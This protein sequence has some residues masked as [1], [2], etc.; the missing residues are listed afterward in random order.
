MDDATPPE[1]LCFG[2]TL[3][4][5]LPDTRGTL[6]DVST[7]HKAV[8][9]APANVA[10]GLAR[11]GRRAAMMGKVGEDDFGHYLRDA[12]AREGVCVKRLTRTHEAHTSVTFISLDHDGERTFMSFRGVTAHMTLRPEEIHADA[13][14]GAPIVVLDSNALVLPHPRAATLRALRLAREQGCFIVID[15][16]IRLHLWPNRDE[17]MPCVWE[18]LSL[19]DAIK[20]NEEELVL[21]AEDRT[22]AELYREQLAPMGV[23]ALWLTRASGGAEVFCGTVHAEVSAPDVTVVD[24]TGAGDGFV[25]GLLTAVCKLTEGAR[26]RATLAQTMR[27]WD[28]RQWARVLGAGCHVGSHVC[29]ILGATPGLPYH[30]E[31]P[32][33]TLLSSSST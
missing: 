30:D 23:T 10:V 5:F 2:E 14:V 19:A 16:N 1:V 15:P 9:G 25:A 17:A 26:E 28:A 21:L 11:L 7:F 13:F 29:T 24:T 4:D 32:W 18:L 8:G 12:L 3:I 6:R 33:D 27:S 20:L 31:V 22:G